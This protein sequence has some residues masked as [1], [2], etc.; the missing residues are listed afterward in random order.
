LHIIFAAFFKST[1]HGTEYVQRDIRIK[2]GR[3]TKVNGAERGTGLQKEKKNA[4]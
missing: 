4:P 1:W 2:C 3:E